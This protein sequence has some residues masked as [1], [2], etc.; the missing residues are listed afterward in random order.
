MAA[1]LSTTAISQAVL[2]SE[3]ECFLCLK[4][5]VVHKICTEYAHIAKIKKKAFWFP[6]RVCLM[7]GKKAVMFALAGTVRSKIAKPTGLSL[8]FHDFE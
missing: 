4:H 3:Y 8:T 7:N 5:F 2:K 6:F 1:I